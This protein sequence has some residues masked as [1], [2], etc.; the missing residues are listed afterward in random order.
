M[1]LC[2]IVGIFI[3]FFLVIQSTENIICGQSE[4]QVEQEIQTPNPVLLNNININTITIGNFLSQIGNEDRK[5]LIYGTFDSRIIILNA[6]SLSGP[7]SIETNSTVKGIKLEDIE[8]SDD[9]IKYNELISWDVNNTLYVHNKDLDLLF[10]ETLECPIVDV[11]FLDADNNGEK[12]IIVATRNDIRAIDNKGKLIWQNTRFGGIEEI[13][14]VNFIEQEQNKIEEIAAKTENKIL[15]Y[16]F[17][18]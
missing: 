11:T 9:E 15:I 5:E 12:D 16:V 18:G 14:T 7:S 10:E 2:K 13:L 8:L 1:K 6:V 4:C 17:N 3:L